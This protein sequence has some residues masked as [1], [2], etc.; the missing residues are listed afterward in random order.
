VTASRRHG[1]FSS[2]K[3]QRPF[4]LKCAIAV[5]KGTGVWKYFQERRANE[6]TAAQCRSGKRGFHQREVVNPTGEVLAREN[7]FWHGEIVVQVF[8]CQS[9]HSV[10]SRAALRV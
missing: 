3:R 2:A 10:S 9:R 1:W 7:K 5:G 6:S 4:T 8:Q